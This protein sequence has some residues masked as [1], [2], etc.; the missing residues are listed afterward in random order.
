FSPAKV[1]FLSIEFTDTDR[2]GCGCCVIPQEGVLDF[3]V[4]DLEKAEGL[5]QKVEN[6]TL[7]DRV[8]EILNRERLLC[9]ELSSEELSAL[10]NYSFI[11]AKPFIIWQ[12]QELNA[13]FGEI[14]QKTRSCVFFTVNKN[15][16]RAW[17]I[18]EGIDV[19]SAASKIHTDLAKG[20]IRA[21]VYNIENLEALKNIEEGKQ[22]GIV[23]VVDRDYIVEDGDVINIKFK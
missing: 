2:E 8:L 15:E 3:V 7:I 11:T 13:L 22:R 9:E 18:Q 10:K 19:V 14:I 4:E 17:L 20:F 6:K 16:A 12:N 23:K 1:S 21:E 5:S